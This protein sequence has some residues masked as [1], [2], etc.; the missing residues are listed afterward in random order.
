ME[1]WMVLGAPMWWGAGGSHLVSV[2][3]VGGKGG[4]VMLV[5]RCI[6]GDGTGVYCVRGTAYSSYTHRSQLYVLGR[7]VW[8]TCARQHPQA[9]GQLQAKHVHPTLV[10]PRP[11]RCLWLGRAHS[12]SEQSRLEGNQPAH[13]RWEELARRASMAWGPPGHLATT[14]GA[15]DLYTGPAGWKWRG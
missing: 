12:W 11:C 10:Y 14:G 5:L 13:G 3:L 8:S 9:E 6:V 2:R 15:I 7:F 4:M 1:W